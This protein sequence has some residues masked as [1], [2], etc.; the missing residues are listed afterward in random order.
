TSLVPSLRTQ[1]RID[2]CRLA[3]SCGLHSRTKLKPFPSAQ[4]LN[5]NLPL[6][7]QNF[8]TLGV[9]VGALPHAVLPIVLMEL[10]SL[11]G[12]FFRR[13]VSEFFCHSNVTLLMSSSAVKYG[14]NPLSKIS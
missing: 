5:V 8:L 10:G 14:L 3:G 9:P 13:C 2:F 4:M 6:R 12:L 1:A 11:D 7:E